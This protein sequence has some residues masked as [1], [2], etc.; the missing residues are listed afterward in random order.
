M[1]TDP[2]LSKPH[3]AFDVTNYHHT[4][5]SLHAHTKQARRCMCRSTAQQFSTSNFVLVLGS[6]NALWWNGGGSGKAHGK[7]CGVV[8]YGRAWMR[9]NPAWSGVV[10]GVEYPLTANARPPPSGII[11][12]GDLE[13][14]N[15]SCVSCISVSDR[16]LWL[17]KASARINLLRPQEPPC[18]VTIG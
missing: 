4:P 9:R 16:W 5:S 1:Y 7:S 18:A 15:N 17:P 14:V 11:K 6:G 2:L 10:C 3:A 12:A 13:Q 8:V